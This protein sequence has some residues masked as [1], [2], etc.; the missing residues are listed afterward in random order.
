MKPLSFFVYGSCVTR[1]PLDELVKTG[2]IKIAS[3]ISK[4]TITSQI[5][6]PLSVVN[7]S[8]KKEDFLT[9][10][11]KIDQE[12][13][14]LEEIESS[15]FDYLIIDFIDE[16]L[17]VIN[18]SNSVFTFTRTFSHYFDS[19]EI[20]KKYDSRSTDKYYQI[21]EFFFKKLTSFVPQEKIIIHR[22]WWAKQYLKENEKNQFDKST[23]QLVHFNNIIL[24][25]TYGM[26]K[27]MLPNSIFI[28]VDKEH[29]LSDFDHKWGSDPYHYTKQYNQKLNESILE[30]ITVDKSFKTHSIKHSENKRII[31][32]TSIYLRNGDTRSPFITDYSLTEKYLTH[33]K[34]YVTKFK[35]TGVFFDEN[36]VPFNNFRWGGPYRYSVTIGHHGLSCLSRYI[37]HQNKKELVTAHNV[38]KYLISNQSSCGSWL[39]EFDHE[40]FPQ[41][42]DKLKAPWTSAMGQGLCISLL[43]R[44]LEL[45]KKGKVIEDLYLEDNALLF[46]AL[47]GAEPYKKLTTAGG[48]ASK[49]FKE[50]LFFE[51]YPTQ[52]GSHVLNGFIYSLLGLYDLWLASQNKHA[53]ELYKKGINTLHECL[54]FY[55]LGVATA[56]DLTHL[57]TIDNPPNIARYNYHFIHVQLLS[58]I[59][60]IENGAFSIILERWNLYLNGW[61][62]KT[63]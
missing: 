61:G 42:C 33:D 48:V 35:D 63:N 19:N 37:A 38:C 25:K 40:W 13:K 23:L 46:T 8:D 26:L 11:V 24:N 41:R 17:P 49:L 39:V 6:P 57:T 32:N 27:K 60:L 10:M 4:T 34:E 53:Y 5:N 7:L 44:Y 47:N 58:A 16:R 20:N 54:K 21:L 62:R 55:D 3:Y 45:Q 29:V 14:V 59:N 51:E 9:R 18:I 43:S 52:P 30:L 12:K 31:E 28:E 1:D 36:D 50:H 2:K 56:Y 22:A 15:D